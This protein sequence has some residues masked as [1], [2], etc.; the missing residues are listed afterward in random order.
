MPAFALFFPIDIAVALTA[1]VHLSNNIFKVFLLGRSADKNI[2]FLFGVPALIASMA[3]AYMLFQCSHIQPLYYYLIGD[4]VASITTLKLFM[5]VLMIFFVGM[6]IHPKF[7]NI[8]FD[9]KYLLLGGILSGF[10]GG[11]SGHQ[12]AL[13]SAF[14]IRCGLSKETFIATGVVIACLIDISR[15]GVYA[16]HFASEGLRA[17]GGILLAAISAAFVGTF[18]GNKLI[19]KVTVD[20]VQKIVA[21]MLFVIAV[22]LAAGI[23]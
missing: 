9:R 7:K 8:S 19:R 11:L 12:G 22:L 20:A 13:R 23:I 5:A 16:T 15:L 21:G 18:L 10:F 1:V 6:E 3:G 14:L 4:K 17:N 2:V